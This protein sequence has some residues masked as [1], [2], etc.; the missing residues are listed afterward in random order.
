MECRALGTHAT[1]PCQGM[2]SY[3][4]SSQEAAPRDP[5][6]QMLGGIESSSFRGAG[7][8]V[9]VLVVLFIIGVINKANQWLWKE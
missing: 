2:T 6:N 4:S 1:I 8:C 5:C 9:I 7:C 3:P